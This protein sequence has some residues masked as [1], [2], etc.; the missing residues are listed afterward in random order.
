MR[1]VNSRARTYAKLTAA[2]AA[3]GDGFAVRRHVEVN[4]AS[5]AGPVVEA[6]VIVNWPAGY[7][8]E[9]WRE[10]AADPF[11]IERHADLDLA[12]ALPWQRQKLARCKYFVSD[13]RTADWQPAQAKR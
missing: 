8:V 9:M 6:Y 1:A 2:V 7:Q 11:A 13:G 10:A 4:G 12:V 3:A 5:V